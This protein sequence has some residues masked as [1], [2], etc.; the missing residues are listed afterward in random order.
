[1]SVTIAKRV[2]LGQLTTLNLNT[3]RSSIIR[4]GRKAYKFKDVISIGSIY[5]APPPL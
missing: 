1:M 2:P 3:V 4:S 5:K